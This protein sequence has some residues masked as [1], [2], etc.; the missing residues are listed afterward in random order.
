MC[1][2]VV[3]GP[4]GAATRAGPLRIG[5]G[6]LRRAESPVSV[7]LPHLCDFLHPL[8]G[9]SGGR[10][11]KK[12]PL[13]NTHTHTLSHYHYPREQLPG[14]LGSESLA[15]REARP[16]G[17]SRSSVHW[18]GAN[19]IFRSLHLTEG[20][21]APRPLPSRVWSPAVCRGQAAWGDSSLPSSSQAA[22]PVPT[23][24][25]GSAM[26]QANPITHK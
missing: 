4:V 5:G 11:H 26:G 18:D 13:P 14:S 22:L 16:G 15:I 1:R 7:T 3:C 2:P 9:V 10:S 20:M 6:W 8:G 17:G 24:A 21:G 25:P 12:T 23:T 19:F